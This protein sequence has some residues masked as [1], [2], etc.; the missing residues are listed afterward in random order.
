VRKR[1][2]K[3]PKR[4]FSKVRLSD[5]AVRMIDQATAD[6]PTARPALYE[7]FAAMLQPEA[8]HAFAHGSPAQRARL[9]FAMRDA[10]KA[11]VDGRHCDLCERAASRVRFVLIPRNGDAAA[12]TRPTEPVE[13][14]TMFAIFCD[15]CAE[16]PPERRNQMML[17]EFN[18]IAEQRDSAAS[19][20]RLAIVGQAVGGGINLPA[21]SA[22]QSCQRC[23]ASIWFDQ[24]DL[25]RHGESDN[26]VSFYC[27]GC[28][29]QLFRTGG[30][31]TV[32]WALVASGRL[33]IP[34]SAC[35]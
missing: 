25:D 34:S 19:R 2:K 30:L 23:G 1:N 33:R 7:S 18:R 32:P 20:R 15:Q 21:R 11:V 24:D 8:M 4:M 27:D 13:T 17:A 35:G 26:G 6:I 10:C 28:A 12:G 16:I 31:E 9:L 3:R 14:L 22:L 29:Q 5:E